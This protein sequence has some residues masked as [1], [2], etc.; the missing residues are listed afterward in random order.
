MRVGGAARAQI[1]G[2]TCEVSDP[3]ADYRVH[4]RLEG[5]MHRAQCSI[6]VNK[7]H[8]HLKQP[9]DKAEKSTPKQHALPVLILA[10][11]VYNTDFPALISQKCPAS[12]A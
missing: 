3:G 7:T 12:N 4:V 5:S 6:H 9:H 1:I 2:L 8:N 10:P 11:T